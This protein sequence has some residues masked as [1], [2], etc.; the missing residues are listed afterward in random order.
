MVLKFFDIQIRISFRFSMANLIDTHLRQKVP[1]H[2]T[3]VLNL[4]N[5]AERHDLKSRLW[6]FFPFFSSS[7]KRVKKKGRV[8]NKNRDLKS[9]LYARS[10]SVYVKMIFYTPTQNQMVILNRK[11][12]LENIK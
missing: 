12:V 11:R 9:C 5:R 2:T 6:L 3:K 7:L 10:Y 4:R 8:N 1:Q